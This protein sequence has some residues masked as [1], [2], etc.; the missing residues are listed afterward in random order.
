MNKSKVFEINKEKIGFTFFYLGLFILPSSFFLS[1]LLLFPAA[2]IGTIK[3]KESY[4]QNIHNKLFF[5]TGILMIFSSFIHRNSFVNF[6]NQIWDSNLSFLGLANWLPFFWLFWGFQYYLSNERYRKNCA[7][8]LI[9]GTFPILVSG[10]S[11]YFLKLYGPYETLNGLIIW[12]QRPL[13]N[14]GLTAVFNNQNYAGTWFNLI[15]PF[16]IATYLIKTKTFKKCA[17]L[18]FL[19]SIGSSI[20]LTNSRN[21]WGG[22]IFCIPIVAGY[23]IITWLLPLLLIV[24]SIIFIAINPYFNGFIQDFINQIFPS[25][26]LKEFSNIQLNSSNIGR[27]DILAF[28]LRQSILSPI[29]GL[30]AGLFPILYESSTGLWKGHSHNI[31]LEVAFN[32]GFPSSCLLFVSISSL[33]FR[34]FIKIFSYKPKNSYFERAWWASIFYFSLSQLTDIQ[35]YDGKI[36]LIAW[37]LLAG[38]KNIIYESETNSVN[39]KENN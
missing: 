27:L 11:Q 38:L 19:A 7:L 18:F 23:K 29:F 8:V 39:N 2:I 26:I 34:S 16:S 13:G 35:Y 4:F 1:V 25:K 32:Y 3:Q 20:I 21:A 28:S 33:L 30:G 12:Y 37:I 9:S 6:N 36:S 15:W 14:E 17:S 5:I 24:I 31:F 22:L 10:F